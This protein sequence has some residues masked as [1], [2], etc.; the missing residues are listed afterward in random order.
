VKVELYLSPESAALVENWG[1]VIQKKL[2]A[3]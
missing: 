2:K 3:N 1:I